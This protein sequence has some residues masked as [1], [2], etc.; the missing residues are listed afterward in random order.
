LLLTDVKDQNMYSVL[1]KTIRN[2]SDPFGGL[3]AENL[4]TLSAIATELWLPSATMLFREGAR[5]WALSGD[6]RSSPVLERGSEI[7]VPGRGA[8]FGETAVLDQVPRSGDALIA[9]EAVLLRIASDYFYDVL[10]ENP[11]L[12]RS[13]LRLLTRRLGEARA[14]IAQAEC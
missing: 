5:R 4:A 11:E 9:D 3:P 13:L 2:V 7:A 14:R 10:A 12:T 8:C 1:E 6:L